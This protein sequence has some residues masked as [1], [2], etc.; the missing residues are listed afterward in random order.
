VLLMAT[1]VGVL[2]MDWL[3]I[4]GLAVS[5]S[6]VVGSIVDGCGNWFYNL[7]RSCLIKFQTEERLP[8]QAPVDIGDAKILV[9]GMGRVGTGAYGYLRKHFG[10]VIIGFEEN[11]E[12]AKQHREAGR[13]IMVGDASDRELWQRIPHHQ[14]EQVILALSNH[15]ETIRV[16][17]LLRN[18][19]YEGVIAAVANYPDQ[20]EELKS[21][22][23]IAF[24]IFAEA[25]AGFAEH[26]HNQLKE[27]LV[28]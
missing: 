24:N 5:L 26:V 6:F 28:S 22:G 17:S 2:A 4:I 12:K 11:L 25:G 10:D 8:E 27:G 20:V 21:L 23:V 15:A 16:A 19:G 3:V 9:M 14:V 7:N 13:E 1:S 18:S